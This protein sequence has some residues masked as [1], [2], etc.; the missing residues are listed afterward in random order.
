ML[1]CASQYLDLEVDAKQR[2]CFDAWVRILDAFQCSKN[3]RADRP[4]YPQKSK[5]RRCYLRKRNQRTVECL[6]SYKMRGDPD[7]VENCLGR[8]PQDMTRDDLQG[9]DGQS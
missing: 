1:M 5:W 2:Q 6:N 3:R 7:V 9:P 4:I 8:I